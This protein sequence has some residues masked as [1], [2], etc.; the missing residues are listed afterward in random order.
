MKGPSFKAN[1]AEFSHPVEKDWK[2]PGTQNP[3]FKF[4]QLREQAKR[5]IQAW[6]AKVTEDPT[7]MLALIQELKTHQAELEIQNEELQQ[8]QQELSILQREFKELYEFAP[9]GY[10]TLDAK[11][12]IARAN[13]KSVELFGA[14]RKL[15]TRLGLTQFIAP[16]W[17]DPFLNALQ[18]AKDTG[19]KQSIEFPLKRAGG[20]HLWV[21]ADIETNQDPADTENSWKIVLVEIKDPKIS[22]AIQSNESHQ[23]EERF[24]QDNR[25]NQA[26]DNQDPTGTQTVEEKIFAD[27]VKKLSEHTI[28]GWLGSLINASVL[29]L[30]LW[31]VT[32]KRRLI[33]WYAGIVLIS[34]SRMVVQK[35]FNKYS[36]SNHLLNKWRYY[37]LATLAASGIVWGSAGFALFPAH[38]MA[39]QSFIAFV[40]GGMVAGSV[41]VFSVMPI[42][43]LCFS[44]P[45][46]LPLT[47]MFFLL[48]D[49]VHLAM[50]F[51]LTLFWL[52]MLMTTKK[53]QND[54]LNTF[55]L[56]Y[57][58]IDLISDLETEV[59]TRKEAETKLKQ[60]K[61]E[62]EQIVQERTT[63]LKESQQ[64]YKEL[65]ENINDVI[66]TVDL[67]GTV[68]YISPVI[69]ALFGYTP[70]EIIDNNF[71]KY[72]HPDDLPKVL[73]RFIKVL[74][75]KVVET[76]YRFKSKWDD[77]RWVRASSRAIYSDNQVCGLTGILSDISER[78]QLE[79]ERATLEGQL[80]QAQKMESI[81]TLAG[82][83]AHDFNNLLAVILG[84]A[85]LALDDISKEDPVF[86]ALQGI[87]SAGLRATGV[88]KQ[89]L[90]FS[91]T[92]EPDL[93]P[94]DAVA[95]VQDALQFLR[96]TIPAN[97][98]IKTHFDAT[99]ITIHAD[100]IQINQTLMNICTN[101]YQ[102]MEMT[103]GQ[104]SISVG[105]K[106]IENSAEKDRMGLPMGDYLRL[107]I[108][109]S[110]PGIAP[111]MI[112]R[113]FDPYFT[114]KEIGKGSGMGLAVVHGIISIHQGA[115]KVESRLGTGTKF[116][117]FLPIH[118]S[119]PET[120][121]AISS[122]KTLGGKESIL[123]VDDE[124][125][126]AQL[127]RKTLERLGYSVETHCNPVEALKRFESEPNYFDLVITDMAMP[128]MTGV[129]LSHQV[130]RLR[131]DIP[132]I[133][134][135]GHSTLINEDNADELGLDAFVHKPVDKNTLAE[136]IRNVLDKLHEPG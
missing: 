41:A 114:T 6:P 35:A 3:W 115:I 136:I 19:Q 119:R 118:S 104:L 124:A 80:H 29:A 65:V 69:A 88:V 98:E 107:S 108:E 57:T 14:E 2:M 49:P 26:P 79:D 89:L 128:Q 99:D 93:R 44:V 132:V 127:T 11:G 32:D 71:S 85:E 74:D 40:L 95:V 43:F 130:K 64:K 87:Q 116:E 70:S 67:K 45:A 73:E 52:I 31:G 109:D 121:C 102:A 105:K 42:A 117:I 48:P 91:R 27:R 8:T 123:F 58:N 21:R 46:L 110:G 28:F 1:C 12:I 66:F 51:M 62:I 36:S 68:S 9:C 18:K 56:K 113:I 76:E 22:A 129:E 16:G 55:K 39:H 103:G 84:N 120:I 47:V 23:L 81:G 131:R 112:N 37:F 133:L 53:I 126:I 30:V 10:V 135:T 50:G 59:Q 38:S 17:E 75:G 4:D 96:S 86:T 54:H 63:A 25:S 100:P 61:I 5:L 24:E 94:I 82:G 15:L 33:T 122:A 125:S 13:H 72:I 92:S 134:C 83:V 90:N 7:N 106:A 34:I 97:I 60:Q 111:E 101:A 78:K 77:Y 20:Q